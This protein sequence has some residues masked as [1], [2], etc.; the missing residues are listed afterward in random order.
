MLTILWKPVLW[1]A[2]PLDLTKLQLPLFVATSPLQRYSYSKSCYRHNT[3]G[4]YRLVRYRRA[5][6]V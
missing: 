4:R 5:L 6:Y 1:L 3:I 2:D